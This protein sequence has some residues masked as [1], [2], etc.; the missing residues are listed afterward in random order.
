MRIE[1]L[2]VE[3]LRLFER[4]EFEPATGINLLVGDNGAGKTSALEA[5]HLLSHGRSFRSS[6]HE[7][8][9]RVGATQLRVF[10]QLWSDRQRRSLRLGLERSARSWNAR[11]D[12]AVIE[13]LSRLFQE[14]AVVCFAPDSH[15]LISGGAEHR[16]RFVDWALFHV[17]Q[18]FIGPWRRY[19]R[20]L[21]Q[22]NSLLKQRPGDA[23]LEPWE[24]EL[25][26]QGLIVDR[27]RQAWFDCFLPDLRALAQRFL[28][29]LG[30]LWLQFRPGSQG[31][32][33]AA[34]QAMLAQSRER[35][36]I[37]GHTLVGAHR[38]DWTLGFEHLPERSMFSRGQE[39]L[40]VLACLLAQAQSFA[41]MRAEWPVLLLDDLPSE[42]DAGH[43]AATLDWLAEKPLQAFITSTRR[44]DL[45]AAIGR[46][47]GVFHVEHGRVTPLV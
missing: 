1:T 41:R 25:A 15:V 33:P 17:E 43:L 10:A 27:L 32:D 45:P 37:M 2:R 31:D 34:M 42:L 28:P 38:S 29:E 14:L 44:M 20:A 21:K 24:W 39:K 8:L 22:R 36:R 3:Q 16:R 35:E 11:L 47:S 4:L 26:E 13:P 5:I 46:Q 23:D 30:E 9:I 40:G 6:Q 7:A 19:Q 12:G 18:G